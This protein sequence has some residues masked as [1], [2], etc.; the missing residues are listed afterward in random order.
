MSARFTLSDSAYLAAHHIPTYLTDVLG[1]IGHIEKGDD[2]QQQPPSQVKA[3]EFL[4][5]Y[6]TL[7]S[8]PA[9]TSAGGSSILH[10]DFRYVNSTPATRLA[11]IAM[12]RRCCCSGLE[13]E[14]LTPESVH[15]LCLLLCVDFP[16][17]LVRNAARIT[18]EV[19]PATAAAASPPPAVG[20][21]LR[22]FSHK[23]FVLFFFSEF[24]NQ[25]ALTFRSI[26]TNGSG[27]VGRSDF[28]ARLAEVREKKKDEFSCPHAQAIE[29]A[30]QTPANPT[31]AGPSS[32]DIMFNSFCVELFAHRRIHEALASD[33]HPTAEE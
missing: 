32:D 19:P 14:V 24:L 6:F 16:F 21:S 33:W 28:R 2:K 17:S 15:Q 4:A 12:F 8:S 1:L 31:G 29:E 9:G 11:F 22:D 7:L 3:I 18:T 20:M 30:L 27:R 5:A 10:R 26:D 13:A 23:L 25:C